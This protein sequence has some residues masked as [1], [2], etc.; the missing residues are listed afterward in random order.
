MIAN[1]AELTADFTTIEMLVAID[2]DDSDTLGLI[3]KLEQRHKWL[4]HC[5][6]QRMNTVNGYYNLLARKS[7]GNYIWFFA[8]DAILETKNWDLLLLPQLQS[9]RPARRDGILCARV[10][11]NNDCNFAHFPIISRAGVRTLGFFFSPGIKGYGSDPYIWKVY[12]DVNRTLRVDN[13]G[14]FHYWLPDPPVWG[15][16]PGGGGD[17]KNDVARLKKSLLPPKLFL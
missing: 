11:E 5:L 14:L 2:L 10:R 9:F 3:V 4:R 6:T 16:V 12:D 7:I 17:L 15:R 13:V 1:I 8:D